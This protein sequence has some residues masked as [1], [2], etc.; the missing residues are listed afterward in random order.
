MKEIS[1]KLFVL[2]GK[3]KTPL[4]LAGLVVSV[5]YGIYKQILSLDVFENVGSN[6]TFIILQNMLE[7]VF[8]LALIS[9]VLGVAS[10]LTT[11]ILGRKQPNL[12][13]NVS[14]LDASLD[15]HNSTYEQDN[16]K[17]KKTI[18]PKGK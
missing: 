15:P 11:F 18:K 10:Y 17:G 3:V 6:S 2:A 9:I 5:L 7:K 12:K 14:L 8:W 1:E 16:R 4:V 13:S